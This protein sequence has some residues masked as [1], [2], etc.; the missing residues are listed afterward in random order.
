[1]RT[2]SHELKFP[3]KT[4]PLFQPM[5]YKV[6]RGGRGSAKSWSIARA[7]IA[8]ATAR[9]MRILCAREFQRS[10]RQSVHQLLSNQIRAMGLADAWSVQQAVIG[11]TNGSEFVFEGLHHNIEGIQ[12]YEGID[13]CWIE[14]ANTASAESWKRLPPTIRA[15]GSEIWASY[16][17]E[18]EDDP[19]HERFSKPRDNAVVI[20]MNWTDNPWFPEVLEQERLD[21]LQYEPDDYN[22]IWEGECRQWMTGAI[23]ASEL[24]A[25]YDEGRVREVPYDPAVQVHTAWDI[26]RTDDTAI[27][28]YQVVGDEIH[29]LES[30]AGS[31]GDASYWASRV[32]GREVQI[33]IIKGKVVVELG[34]PIPDIEHRQHYKYGRHWLPH[35]ARAKTFAA[36]GKSVQEQLRHAFG[37]ATVR[38]VPNL[39]IE[40][41]IKMVR[42]A[43]RRFYFDKEGC[44]D[45]LKA[46][47]RYEREVK[48]D[49]VSQSRKPKHDWTSHSMDAL[50]MLAVAFETKAESKP[51]A[52]PQRDGYD[53]GEDDAVDWKVA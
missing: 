5:R 26:G 19:T 8:M 29:L 25:A 12:S 28:F 23:Y 11:G 4:K 31:G 10:I 17:P 50:R 41:G 24:R 52:K 1:M 47:R 30:E 32:L 43:F 45:G 38:I 51:E 39:S 14:E 16:N 9:P 36:M 3:P 20:D 42:T 33:D 40:D 7:L 46:A 49:G 22:W 6:L 34:D 48:P 35:D 15:P 21:C 44:A 37:F 13:I 18:F 27:W 2:L 53:W